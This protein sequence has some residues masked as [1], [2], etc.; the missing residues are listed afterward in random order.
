[1]GLL[2]NH[3]DEFLTYDYLSAEDFDLMFDDEY[4]LWLQTQ[5]NKLKLNKKTNGEN[6]D[7][8]HNVRTNSDHTC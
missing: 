1:M 3:Y 2:K 8:W 4:E 6:N 5:K 7:D